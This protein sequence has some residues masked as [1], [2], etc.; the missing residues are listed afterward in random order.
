MFDKD[1]IWL[2]FN[3]FFKLNSRLR[4]ILFAFG[5]GGLTY[6]LLPFFTGYLFPRSD[7]LSSVNDLP[8]FIITFFTHPA[9]YL[10]YCFEQEALMDQLVLRLA[11]VQPAEDYEQFINHLNASVNRRVWPILASFLTAVGYVLHVQAVLAHPT[12]SYYY[13]NKLILFFVNAPLS[14]L[15]GY[16]ICLVSI[17]YLIVVIALFKGF[18]RHAPNINVADPDGC[19]GLS[20]IGKFVLG[21]FVLVAIMAIDLSL[22]VMINLQ[23]THRDPFTEPSFISLISAYLFLLPAG[24][25]IPLL[26]TRSSIQKMN[27]DRR[28][29]V[30]PLDKTSFVQFLILFTISLGPILLLIFSKILMG[31][32]Q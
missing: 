21:S 15:A 32:T 17:R 6:L 31:G 20:F 3:R 28:I 30:L 8:G 5:I 13:P 7:G 19:G 10:Y 1:P 29:N 18:R 26:S 2:L 16:M 24:F 23:Q 25:I 11:A 4:S 12:L 9:I 27:L 14:A 22:L